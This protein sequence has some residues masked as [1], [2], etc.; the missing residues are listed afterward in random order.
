M[1]SFVVVVSFAAQRENGCRG[2]SRGRFQKMRMARKTDCDHDNDNE[3][4]RSRKPA[5]DFW[6]TA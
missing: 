1:I 4:D 2:G 3:E 5:I 6:G